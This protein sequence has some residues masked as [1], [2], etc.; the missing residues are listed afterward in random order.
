MK[1]QEN[2]DRRG[3]E[4]AATAKTTMAPAGATAFTTLTV[5]SDTP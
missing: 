5:F 3:A 1:M 4:K 2:S